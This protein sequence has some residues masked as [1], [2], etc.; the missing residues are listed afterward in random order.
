MAQS[1]I[2]HSPISRFGSGLPYDFGIS[3][4]ESMAGCG[5][6]VPDQDHPNFLNPALLHFN[7]KVNLNSDLRYTYRTLNQLNQ[8]EL[9]SGSAGLGFLSIVVPLT[10]SIS[11]G[12]GIRPYSAREF[13]YQQLR[14]AGSDSI[15]VRT[16]G[17]GGLSQTF[18]SCGIRI[19]KN[20][21]LGLEGS[22]VFGTLEDSIAFGVLPSFINYTFIS[23]SK[24]KVSQF[25]LKPGVQLTFPF[26]GS[27]SSFIA[28]GFTSEIGN[29]FSLKKYNQFSVAGTGIKD[30]LENEVPSS[31]PRPVA[32]K[33]GLGIFSPL[34]YS[35]N[36]E[37]EFTRAG[38]L[39]SDGSGFAYSDAITWRL[40]GEYC[41][42][43]KRSTTYLN[44]IHYRAGIMIRDYPYTI[45]GKKVKDLRISAGA[46][47]P[48]VRKD[49]KF[50][51]PIINL[52]VSAGRRGIA[53][54]YVGSENYLQVTM[55]FTLNDFLWFNR[56]KID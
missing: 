43:S 1:G 8:S 11:A 35:I 55:G 17:L 20:I 5:V 45:D 56:Y 31:I 13:T 48:I 38:N 32:M 18:L 21:S 37:A 24:R 23:I 46:S 10:N 6:A 19:H 51:R 47:F 3:R 50:S 53:N 4:N 49:A 22:Y 14:R 2:G 54:S 16:R 30:T 33:F 41:P 28:A 27:E 29:Q 12:A 39:A 7:R 52:S 15:G 34:S 44:L 42:G 9:K 25:L 36:A 40:G 26:P